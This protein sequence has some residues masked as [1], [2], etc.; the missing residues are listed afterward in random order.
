MI[1]ARRCLVDQIGDGVFYQ[2]VSDYRLQR[3]WMDCFS[4]QIRNGI[5]WQVTIARSD[6]VRVCC[7]WQSRG[8]EKSDDDNGDDD[9][10]E[11]NIQVWK[12]HH[13][14]HHDN[15]EYDL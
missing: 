9:H 8:Q 14:H 10:E 15:Q 11:D 13:D 2:M 6:E 12:M 7:D 1:M 4:R 5:G 3:H